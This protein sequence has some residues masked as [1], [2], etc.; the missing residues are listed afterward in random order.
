M[1]DPIG[2]EENAEK[3]EC[4]LTEQ[5]AEQTEC[6]FVCGRQNHNMSIASKSSENIKI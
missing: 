5:N 6:M 4:L 2:L 3:T 1:F